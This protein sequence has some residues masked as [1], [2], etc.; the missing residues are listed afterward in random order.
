[1]RN[2]AIQSLAARGQVEV[3]LVDSGS[4]T[5]EYRVFKDL[6]HEL[7]LPVVYARSRNRETIQA[8]WNRGIKLARAPYP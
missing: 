6:M 5:A 8:A 2:I 1:M 7:S 4:P 3:V